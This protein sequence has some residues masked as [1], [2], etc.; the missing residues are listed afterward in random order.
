MIITSSINYFDISRVCCVS[1][2]IALLKGARAIKGIAPPTFVTQSPLFNV[3]INDGGNSEQVHI[4]SKLCG[5]GISRNKA[6]RV[7]KK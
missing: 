4:G 6:K 7:S 5:I 3:M 1:V 2:N